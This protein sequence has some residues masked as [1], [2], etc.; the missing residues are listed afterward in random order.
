MPAYAFEERFRALNERQREA[1]ALLEG[2]VL[3]IAGPGSGK[4]ELISM[5]VAHILAKTDARPDTIL[6]LTF[7]D[8]AAEN[9]RDRLQGI[10]GRDAYRV[11][12]CTFHSFSVNIIN[13]H[14]EY[15]YDGAAFS[16]ANNI[17]QLEILESIIKE[18]P[19]DNPL[20]KE[21]PEQGFV[22]MHAIKNALT[23]LKKAGL[24][25][26]AYAALCAE[27]EK[28]IRAIN[29]H[30]D[31]FNERIHMN[32]IPEIKKCAARCVALNETIAQAFA[33][34]LTRA[35]T[36]TEE[37]NKSAPLSAWKEE[38]TRKNDAGE[39]VFKDSLYT[40]KCAAL[41]G[42]YRAYREQMHRQGYYDFDDMLLDVL[43]ALKTSP[44]LRSMIEDQY[45]YILVDEFQD[46]N[47][48]QM[49]LLTYVARAD[50]K[51]PNVM[52]VGD[53]DQAIYKFQGADVSNIIEFKKRFM[54]TRVVHLQHNYRSRQD[55]IDLA[56]HIIIQGKNQ[57]EKQDSGEKNK[58][59]TRVAYGDTA[60]SGGKIMSHSFLTNVNECY[61]IAQT[62]KKMI[63]EGVSPHD[64]A[65]IARHHKDLQALQPYC[66]N[67]TVPVTY[68][69][70]K[71][72][73][74]EPH[75]RAI[76]SIA[77]YICTLGRKNRAE[78]D[79]YLPEIISF[80]FWGLDRKTIWEI[81]L[82]AWEKH[83]SWLAA[84]RDHTDPRLTFMVHFF[85]DL[86]NRSLHEPA[87]YIIDA[88]IGSRAENKYTS[89]FRSYYFSPVLLKNKPTE[90]LSFLT[91]LQTFIR[92][93]R[94]YKHKQFLTLDDVMA[95]VAMHEKNN[96][97]ITDQ[98]SDSAE[99]NAVRLLTAHK[100]K[101]LEFGAVFVMNCAD[102][103]WASPPRGALLP[104]PINLPIAPAGDTIDDQLRLFYVAITRAKHTLY[105]T[106]SEKTENGRH[107][108]R[109]RFLE[110]L[111]ASKKEFDTEETI[112]ALQVRGNRCNRAPYVSEENTILKT[113]V[114]K[115]QLSVTHLNNFLNVAGGGPHTFLEQNLLRFP[116]AKTISGSFG[117]AMHK[118]I[119]RVYA[120]FKKEGALPN[121]TILAAW[122]V[123]ALQRERL[124]EQEHKVHAKRGIHALT[125]W[126]ASKKETFRA[127]DLIEIKFKNQ[128][129]MVN[130]AHLTGKIDKMAFTDANEIEVHDFKTGK[131]ADSWEGM[132]KYEKIKL[133]NYKRQLLFYKLLIENS[134][135]FGGKYTMRKGILE[136]LEPHKG[137][138]IDL[139]LTIQKEDSDRLTAL[140]GVVYAKIKALDFPDISAYSKDV[141]GI[142]AFENDLLQ[143]KY[144]LTE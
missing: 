126:Y 37:Q 74:Q 5:R 6:C 4:T 47:D 53:D 79:E 15:F 131:S 63:D 52:A 27:N 17:T 110:S 65:V 89:P 3:V 139:P 68:E 98:N 7:T 92:A 48:A 87:E 50:G 36:T 88:I 60:R 121:E 57:R 66:T 1:V 72:V 61:W 134:R 122:F 40:E 24:T 95:F 112:N 41:A 111:T 133:H 34:S 35:I 132:N 78:A 43:E 103:V 69:R 42:L 75:I 62:I 116:Q 73:L 32:R 127:T 20:R 83:I 71:N 9:M 140:I 143:K 76:I 86:A 106:S 81:S 80:P 90:Y 109:A 8:A 115:Y 64:I 114:N 141:N 22:Y 136:F 25:P 85:L 104:F 70:Q 102:S 118:T 125:A 46:T 119:E 38:W 55:I 77:R 99:E 56:H 45:Q 14:P 10:I 39:R 100:A 93:F 12:I 33:Q 54:G 107:S 144:D 44:L 16:P 142:I 97:P 82:Y 108:P 113:L 130:G 117:A 49:R 105:L 30:M 135:E 31:I 96:M 26:D 84:M 94:A 23:Q 59:Y 13:R 51:N 2:P 18:L 138:S 120:V 129:V 124:P 123:E 128:G 137:M 101:G 58:S 29:A 91:A 28:G 11:A 19:Y 67:C 21:H